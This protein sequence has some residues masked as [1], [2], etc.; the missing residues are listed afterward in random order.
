MSERLGAGQRGQSDL[1]ALP[2][3]VA[4]PMRGSGSGM[5]LQSY[6]K[7]RQRDRVFFV[8]V[9][10]RGGLSSGG[11]M[12]SSERSLVVVPPPLAAP[13]SAAGVPMPDAGRSHTWQPLSTLL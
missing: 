4:D 6:S 12:P 9:A 8:V 1:D 5:A 10:I 13:P 2:E 7:L 3:A 11:A